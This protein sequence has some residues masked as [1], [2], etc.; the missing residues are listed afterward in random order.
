MKWLPGRLLQQQRQVFNLTNS[1]S[2]I[3]IRT[4]ASSFVPDCPIIDFLFKEPKIMRCV[5]ELVM[6]YIILPY[7]M[8]KNWGP[9][10]AHTVC[11]LKLLLYPYFHC[12]MFNDVAVFG[13]ANPDPEG[14]GFCQAGFSVDF[15]KVTALSL[16][17]F[18]YTHS[19]YIYI[20][21]L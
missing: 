7:N 3:N 4:R 11:V 13:A 12:I 8:I 21:I 14:Q 17:H 1:A 15:T 16:H 9:H 10:F 5:W 6:A 20:F 18:V 2:F 19:F